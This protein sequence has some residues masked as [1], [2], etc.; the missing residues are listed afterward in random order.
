MEFRTIVQ[1]RG[2]IIRLGNSLDIDSSRQARIDAKAEAVAWVA[3]ALND[4]SFERRIKTETEKLKPQIK[5]KT[6]PTVGVL[7]CVIYTQS[8]DYGYKGFDNMYIADAGTDYKMVLNRY[9]DMPK[10]GAGVNSAFAKKEMLIWVT[11]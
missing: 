11:E 7:L 1:D 9:Q 8:V 5:A 10:M 6:S 2:G 4:F 3:N